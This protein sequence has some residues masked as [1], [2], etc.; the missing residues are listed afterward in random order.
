MLLRRLRNEGIQLVT[1]RLASGEEPRVAEAKYADLLEPCEREL[2]LNALDA[3]L[4]EILASSQPFDTSIDVRAAPAIHRALRLSRR[5]AS[6]PGVWRFLAVV[7]R[8]DFVRHRW[9][10]KSWSTMRSRFWSIGTRPD[11]NA[12][13][14]L[15]WIAELSRQE[16]SYELTERA[17][18][19]Q[20]L[21]NNVF[22]R[23]LSFYQPAVRACIEV[24]EN[25]PQEVIERAMLRF[26]RVL[27]T[28]SLESQ[29]FEDLSSLLR[30]AAPVRPAMG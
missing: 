13:C 4:D 5:E 22:V 27:S 17:L 8:P 14:R 2:S 1:P 21:A 18:R 28:V 6:E 3:A 11:S 26:N 15:W 9:E 20:V 29:S 19:R 25:E 7:H 23:A 12:L 16:D 24:L 30:E 10:N